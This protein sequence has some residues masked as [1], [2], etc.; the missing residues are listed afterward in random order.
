LSSL[1]F[2]KNVKIKTHETIILSVVLLWVFETRLLRIFGPKR[3]EVAG[4]WRRVYSTE[5]HN[6]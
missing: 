5:L 4:E 6:L 3:E 2:S 1:L